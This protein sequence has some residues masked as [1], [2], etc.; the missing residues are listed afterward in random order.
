MTKDKLQIIDK[1]GELCKN[2]IDLI[3]QSNGYELTKE[4]N[5]PES[6]GS[7][8]WV[9]TNYKARHCYR[10]IWD[11]KNEWFSL[12]ESPFIN[13]PQKVGFADVI[14]VDFNG[15]VDN[16]DNWKD[17]INEIAAEIQ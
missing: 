7:K 5:H 4:E 1:F 15:H 10:F 16:P 12:E 14:V 13:D 6:F 9:W 17:I 2:Q 11:G 3:L 8:Y